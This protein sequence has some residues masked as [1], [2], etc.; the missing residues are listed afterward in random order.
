MEG[1]TELRDVC[2]HVCGKVVEVKK[3]H[4]TSKM[5]QCRLYLISNTKT[6]DQK[7]LKSH[8]TLKALVWVYGLGLQQLIICHT[9]RN[10]CKTKS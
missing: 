3:T 6:F 8:L 9:D 1:H 7:W 2:E 4:N 10:L 5:P